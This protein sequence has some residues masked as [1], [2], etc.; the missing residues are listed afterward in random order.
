MIVLK[1]GAIE[2]RPASGLAIEVRN[3]QKQ[4]I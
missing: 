4:L 2:D 3:W 1:M